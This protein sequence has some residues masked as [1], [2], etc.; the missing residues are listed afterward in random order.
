MATNTSL[1]TNARIRPLLIS[2]P[3]VWISGENP[4]RKDPYSFLIS[5]AAF[6]PPSGVSPHNSQCSPR[7]DR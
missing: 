4:G 7:R 6:F 2:A 3:L 1:M 5:H